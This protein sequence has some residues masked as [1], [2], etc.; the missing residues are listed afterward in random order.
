M[1]SARVRSSMNLS[2]LKRELQRLAEMPTPETSAHLGRVIDQAFLDTQRRVHVETGVLK[3]SGERVTSS[4]GSEW[5]GR[6]GYGKDPAYYGQW[7]FARDGHDP[8][9]GLNQYEDEISDAV[10]RAIKDV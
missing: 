6:I 2:S 9:V 1:A 10:G 3:A 5:R 7:E 8:F 4:Y